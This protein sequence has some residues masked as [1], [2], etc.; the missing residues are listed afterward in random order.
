MLAFAALFSAIAGPSDVP[1]SYEIHNTSQLPMVM[2][3]VDAKAHKLARIG[4]FQSKIVTDCAPDRF[5]KDFVMSALCTIEE[6]ELQVAGPD[7]E[8]GTRIADEITE[9]LIGRDVELRFDKKGSLRSV[10]LAFRDGEPDYRPSSSALAICGD[11]FYATTST[12]ASVDFLLAQTFAALDL[13]V[14]AS[15]TTWESRSDRTLLPPTGMNPMGRGSTDYQAERVD[16]GQQLSY[17]GFGKFYLAG[18]AT[19]MHAVVE[20]QGTAV[21]SDDGRILS[22]QHMVE[23]DLQ[24]ADVGSQAFQSS[25]TVQAVVDSQAVASQ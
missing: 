12:H 24:R 9:D 15:A 2:G 1:V 21:V 14:P 3:L 7:A 13:S 23:G 5:K 17:S 6:F 18:T 11:S 8:L 4:G 10:S 25:W 22:R 16:A 20:S 19:E